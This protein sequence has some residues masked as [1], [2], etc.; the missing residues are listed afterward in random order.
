VEPKR[1]QYPQAER[2]RNHPPAA[3]R[4]VSAWKILV[5]PTESW[6]PWVANQELSA[7]SGHHEDENSA[8]K[9]GHDQQRKPQQMK[10][11]I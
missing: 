8:A 2:W 11:E 10:I 9:I 4:N 1:T 7:R 5:S 3:P 6:W